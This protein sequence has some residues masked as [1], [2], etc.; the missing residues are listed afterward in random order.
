VNHF[1]MAAFTVLLTLAWGLLIVLRRDAAGGPKQQFGLLLIAL[2]VALLL[3]AALLIPLGEA[4]PYLNRTALTLQEAGASSL[5][6]ASLLTTLIPTYGG[7]PEQVIYLGLPIA[8]LAVV[9]LVLKRDRM[10]WFLAIVAALAAVF[11]LGIHGPLFPFLFRW[12]PGLSWL[13]VP[14]RA[15]MI[16][17]FCMALLA[18]R[19]L[20]TLVRTR[21]RPA[22]RRHVTLVGLV[23]LT[24]GLTL[25]A[26]LL[27][28]FRPIP[29]AAWSMSALTVLTV[30]ALLL[31]ARSRLPVL[32]FTV[33]ILILATV[34]LGLVFFGWTEMRAPTDAFAWG[35]ETA[36]YLALQPKPFR[37]YSPSYSLPQHTAVQQDLYLADGVDP[38]QLSHYAEFLAA[39]GGYTATGYSPTL[40]PILDDTS[41]L[42]DATRLGLLNVGYVVASFPFTAES[43]VLEEQI[44]DTYVYRNEQVLPRAFTMPDIKTLTQGNIH[45][46]ELSSATPARIEIYTPNRI[47]V[48]ADLESA[49]LLVLSE[50]WY[51]GWRAHVDGVE[52]PIWHVEGTFRGVDVDAGSHSIEF[53]YSPGTA[54]TGLAVSGLTAL[55]MITFMTWRSI[56]RPPG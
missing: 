15:W 53:S 3:S 8:I 45:L 46:E 6:W 12:I 20:D 7:Q 18:G 44:S 34:D 27:V 17:A 55:A 38:I 5:P 39:A 54:R 25:P 47:V 13:R 31:R 33:T 10:G 16:V 51:P 32:P 41:S 56:W 36:E 43:L 29:R 37:S 49:G 35:A 42:P 48:K 30:A 9:G 52:V 19:G 21:P 50:V 24:V 4:L 28:L 40:P 14:P 11:A 26:G 1:Q 23:A 2:A 22:V